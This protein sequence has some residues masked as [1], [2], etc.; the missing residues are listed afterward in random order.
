[1][2]TKILDFLKKETVLAVAAVLA[3]CSAFLV[4]PSKAYLGY[5]DFK[6][7]GTLLSLMILM[8]GF[9]KNGLFDR[10]GA[11]LLK[12]TKNTRQLAVVLVMLC[13]FFSMLITNDVA[14]ITFV[15]FTMLVLKACGKE[16]LL[17]PVIV[18]QTVAANLGSMLTPVGNPQ[19]LFLYNLG[20]FGLGEFVGIMLPYA[21]VSLLGILA[22]TLV[23]C[24]KT[25]AITVENALVSEV[26]AKAGLRNAVYLVLFVLSLLVVAKVLPYYLVL[27]LV[28]LAT[29]VLDWRVLKQVDYSLLFTFSFFFIFTGNIGQMEGAK[30][31]LQSIVDGR[32]V[33]VGTAASQVIS[34]VPAALLLSGF[35]ADY[36]GLL[37]GVNIGG[38][39]TMIASMASLI[40]YKL[41]AHSYNQGKGKYF[42]YFT[43]ANVVF[44]VLLLAET[45]ILR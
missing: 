16:K 12:K 17:I 19:N 38:L 6:V 31:W 44:L 24:R 29:L 42:L 37:I 23:V 10:I 25:E 30:A 26:D 13:F 8:A 7:L 5:I 11:W 27:A 1:M 34:N 28:V 20:G 40:S 32:A 18:M 3:V 35:T 45:A 39:G 22:W 15:P 36:E 21:A 9:Q 14:L 2:K 33:L 43:G 4:P 41:Y